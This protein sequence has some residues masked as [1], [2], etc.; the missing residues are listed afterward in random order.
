MRTIVT[1]DIHLGS[2]QCRVEAFSAFLETLP[3]G[4]RLVLNGDVVTHFAKEM[5]MPPEHAAVLDQLRAMSYER[6][7]IW[8]RGN[9]DRH[10]T[11]QDPGRIVFASDYT[12]DHT[13]YIAHGDR[14]DR[15]MPALRFALVPI[16]LVYEFCTR[17]AGT[18]THVAS[19]AKRFPAVYGILNG[20]VAHNALEYAR[21]H[22]CR[23]VTCG[24]THH[25]ETRE[26]DG[27]RY[28]N[29]GCWTEDAT[30]IL[31]VENGHIGLDEF[32]G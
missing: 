8:I 26:G 27:V 6:D 5:S 28:F 23:A 15:L 9:N 21:A 31:N 25:P 13:L 7:I 10:F 30:H 32:R 14:F 22:G 17:V 3:P 20:H 24:H 18:K 16:R 29:T 1:S 4:D 11:M 19:F 12:L 2:R